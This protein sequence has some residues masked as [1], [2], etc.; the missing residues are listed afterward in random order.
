MEYLDC[1]RTNCEYSCVLAPVYPHPQM[2]VLGRLLCVAS[3]CSK[4]GAAP[5]V[6]KPPIETERILICGWRRDIRDVLKACSHRSKRE[7]SQIHP[8]IQL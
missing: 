2:G 4:V 3:M 1:F 6:E 5:I 8:L 7:P